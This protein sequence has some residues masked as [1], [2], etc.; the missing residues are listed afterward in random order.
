MCFNG[1]AL[2]SI[3]FK[4]QKQMVPAKMKGFCVISL[5]RLIILQ[6]E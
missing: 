2:K 6:T 5:L 3:V 1:A 4:K